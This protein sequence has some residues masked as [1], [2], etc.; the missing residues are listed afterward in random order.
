MHVL[1]SQNATY[2]LTQQTY[3]LLKNAQHSS[4]MISVVFTADL[5]G[6]DY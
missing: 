1:L 5:P 3:Y 6:T 2:F 4:N